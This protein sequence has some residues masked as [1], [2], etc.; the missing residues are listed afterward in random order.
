[1]NEEKTV[2]GSLM[3]KYPDL[4]K[5]IKWSGVGPGWE[6]LLDELCQKLSKLPEE[7]EVHQVKEKFGSLRFYIDKG[8]EEAFKI[9]QEAEERSATICE[10]CGQPGRI[11]GK[12]WVHCCC[13]A[14]YKE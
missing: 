5:H 8:S 6:S 9:I 12:H 13:D 10:Q 1:M 7:I 11:R 2:I 3:A 4:F 14:C